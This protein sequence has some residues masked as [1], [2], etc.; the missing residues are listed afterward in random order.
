MA[1]TA[2]P[3]FRSALTSCIETLRSLADYELGPSID[4]RML[5][6]GERKDLLGEREHEEL[7]ALVS[8]VQQR[9][10]ERLQAR[11]ALKQLQEVCPELVATP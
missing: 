2:D 11:V 9:N 5:E 10:L 1:S 6:L 4:R 3:Q 8:F 7:T